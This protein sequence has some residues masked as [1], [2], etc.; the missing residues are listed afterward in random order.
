MRL[1]GDS[2]AMNYASHRLTPKSVWELDK[3]PPC[4]AELD[5][6]VWMQR[7]WVEEREERQG[8]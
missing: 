4:G 2:K 5:R 8:V 1:F 7:L 6:A 3:S